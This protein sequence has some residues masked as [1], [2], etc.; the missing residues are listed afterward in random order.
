[1]MK[2]VFPQIFAAETEALTTGQ[3]L[4]VAAWLPFIFTIRGLAG[5]G[6]V[7][8][9]QLAGVRVLEKLRL[10]FFT[11]LQHLP[12]A[13]LRRQSS[14]DLISRGLA[15]TNQLQFTLTF[16][17]NEIIR[18]PATLLGSIGF[19][20]WTAFNERGVALVLVCLAV[21]PL[22]VL[23]IR[24]VGRKIERRAQEVQK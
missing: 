8:L 15:D 13:F 11:K 22:C 5:Y 7:Y 9:V 19:L 23:P 10:D 2:W 16:A 14:G 18:Q 24:F 3:L 12:L 17:A 21:V 1:M 6:N 4:L 20:I